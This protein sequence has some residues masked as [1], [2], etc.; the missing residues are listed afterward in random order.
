VA[1]CFA[2]LCGLVGWL[3]AAVAGF[4]DGD[5]LTWILREKDRRTDRKNMCGLVSF[6]LSLCMH[7]CMCRGREGMRLCV[8]FFFD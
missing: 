2:C 4:C 8:G 7:A 1:A 5:L 3:T 6:F